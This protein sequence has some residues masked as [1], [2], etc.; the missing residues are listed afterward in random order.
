MVAQDMPCLGPVTQS[1]CGALCPAFGRGCYGCFG[2]REQ[3]NAG[4]LARTF[5]A[6]GREGQDISRLFAGF[7][8]WAAPFRG[9]IGEFGGP[10][11][12]TPVAPPVAPPVPATPAEPEGA[13]HARR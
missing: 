5:E 6:G 13:D 3:A 10:P 1:G 7:T 8:G 9:V 2:P 4:S 11:G 12:R